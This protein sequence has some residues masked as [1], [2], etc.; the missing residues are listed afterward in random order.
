[1]CACIAI[2]YQAF[3]GPWHLAESPAH[4]HPG[5]PGPA[6]LSMLYVSCRSAGAP[7]WP[8]ALALGC[9]ALGVFV[10]AVPLVPQIQ[11]RSTTPLKGYP[12]G[13]ARLCQ[14]YHTHR[15]LVLR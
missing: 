11:Q 13:E 6:F 15:S 10:G 12:S 5:A 2:L 3:R 1:M 4:A 8:A 7:F 14:R 9:I